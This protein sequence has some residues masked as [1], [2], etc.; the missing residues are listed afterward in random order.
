M[1]VFTPRNGEDLTKSEKKVVFEIKN[2]AEELYRL[3]ES[4]GVSRETSVSKT[5]LEECV[6]WAV[7]GVA[8]RL[9]DMSS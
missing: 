7:K 4:V 3:I 6:M 5:K 1:S 8:T 9:P 2:K